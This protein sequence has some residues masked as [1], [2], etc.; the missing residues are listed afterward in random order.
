MKATPPGFNLCACGCGGLT[1]S[2]WKTG[3]HRRAKGAK[4]TIATKPIKQRIAE[5]TAE[6]S[7]GCWEWQL[8]KCRDGYGMMKV[9]GKTLRAARVSYTEFKGPIPEGLLVF[10]VCKNRA[11]VNPDHLEVITS[12][13][14]VARGAT[15]PKVNFAAY[16]ERRRAATHCPHGHPWDSENTRRD[17]VQRFCRA[18]LR[19]NQRKRRKDPD[20]IAKERERNREIYALNRDE[21]LE[22][23]RRYTRECYAKA[24]AEGRCVYGGGLRCD[25][26]AVEGKSQCEYHLALSA[27][28]TWGIRKHPLHTIYKERGIQTCWIC[29]CEFTAEDPMCNDHLIPRSLGGPDEPWNLA[30][31]CRTCNSRRSNLPLN[32]TMELAIHADVAV[33]DF[34]DEYLEYLT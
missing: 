31:I 6:T 23:K 33:A 18:C 17:E 1:K 8:S 27:A 25:E 24:K 11:C 20:F 15:D 28:R 13:E 21:I 29:D 9:A 3:H 5:S 12:K 14:S 19:E 26:P 10:Q 7:S 22:R 32:Q 4:P 34:P 2:T 16:Y 30:P